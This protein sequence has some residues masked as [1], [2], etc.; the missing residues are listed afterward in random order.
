MI[1][2]SIDETATEALKPLQAEY[3]AR[4]DAIAAMG[5]AYELEDSIRR[6]AEM[7]TELAEKRRELRSLSNKI[8]RLRID[9]FKGLLAEE[10]DLPLDHPKFEKAFDIA[11]SYGHGSGFSDV[12]NYF[13]ELV[14]LAK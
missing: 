9:T 2:D 8:E 12:E 6:K 11:W 14:E 10:Y 13:M 4:Y 1:Y 3:T 7:K 5:E